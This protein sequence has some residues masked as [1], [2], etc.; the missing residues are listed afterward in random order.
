MP[1][2]LVAPTVT[3]EWRET[4]TLGIFTTPARDFSGAKGEARM[5]ATQPHR[6]EASLRWHA[7]CSIV[8]RALLIRHSPHETVDAVVRH[9]QRR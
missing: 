7:R 6:R 2:C 4:I 8:G 1:A 9:R 5:E 3:H